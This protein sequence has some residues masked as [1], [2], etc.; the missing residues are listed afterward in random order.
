MPEMQKADPRARRTAILIVVAA[1]VVG[2]A[3]LHIIG[4][5][6]EGL[7]AWAARDPEHAAKVLF[8]LIAPAISVPLL[9]LA[10]WMERF[11][12]KVKRAG[13]YPPPD[14]RLT[15]DTRVRTGADALAFVRL[16]RILAGIT[17]LVAIGWPVLLWRAYRLLFGA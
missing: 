6:S 9:G 7:R 15:S 4:K 2:A 8:P 11:A 12:S 13:R 1:S 10:V 16:H 14:A 5:S 3:S 17:A